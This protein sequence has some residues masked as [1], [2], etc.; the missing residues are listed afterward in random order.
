MEKFIVGAALYER[1]HNSDLKCIDFSIMP[2]NENPP[3]TCDTRTINHFSISFIP[4]NL[5]PNL[6][7]FPAP[8]DRD[9]YLEIL[10]VRTPSIKC[11]SEFYKLI[12]LTKFVNDNYE[13]QLRYTGISSTSGY[14]NDIVSRNCNDEKVIKEIERRFM[15]RAGTMLVKTQNKEEKEM[16]DCKTISTTAIHARDINANNCASIPIY[17]IPGISKIVFNNPATIVFWE[18]GAK[19]VVK[20]MEGQEF[21]EYYGVACAIMKRYFGNNS[22]ATNFIDKFKEEEE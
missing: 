17:P 3:I 16:T 15:K 5:F 20:C 19:T 7:R 18:G 9:V 14:N 21:N 10:G 4:A 2:M 22:K 1:N 8:I 12:D 6:T 13:L 11:E